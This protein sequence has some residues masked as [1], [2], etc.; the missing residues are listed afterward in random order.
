MNADKVIERLQEWGSGDRKAKRWQNVELLCYEL[1]KVSETMAFGCP[2]W[3]TPVKQWMCIMPNGV[4]T[5]MDGLIFDL[6]P[7]LEAWYFE[8]YIQSTPNARELDYIGHADHW[9]RAWYWVAATL[10]LFRAQGYPYPGI[11]RVVQGRLQAIPRLQHMV[12]GILPEAIDAY[13]K[14]RGFDPN[15][16]QLSISFSDI[17]PPD[18]KIAVYQRFDCEEGICEGAI[19]VNPKAFREEGMDYL[20]WVITHEIVHYMLNTR[21]QDQAHGGEF[22]AVSNLLRIPQQFQD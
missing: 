2:R 13:R 4:T 6:S 20:R 10:A 22:Q 1:A 16:G 9:T 19:S 3:D 21:T 15:L 17:I 5:R 11:E 12:R 14:V 18:G 7:E 8:A